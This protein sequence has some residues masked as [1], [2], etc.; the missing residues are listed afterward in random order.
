M[1]RAVLDTVVLVPGLQRDFLLQL[2]AEGAYTPLWGSGILHE[3][4]YVL[5]AL[6]ERRSV[7]SSAARRAHLLEQMQK[8]FPGALVE[9]PK[10]RQYS[11]DIDDPD[12]G[13]VVHA[14]IIGNADALVTGDKR[15]GFEA[16]TALEEAEVEVVDAATF[17]ANCVSAHLDAGIGAVQAMSLRSQSPHRTPREILAELAS[18]YDMREVEELL[19]PSFADS[20]PSSRQ[21]ET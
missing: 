15:A 19:A 13:H 12:D 20:G 14:S 6:H 5:E 17:A 4:D 9:A 21:A 3:L 10:N 18:R 11:Y 16:S 7:T 1:Y 8:A 2:A